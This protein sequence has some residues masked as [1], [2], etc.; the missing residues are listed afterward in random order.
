M[1]GSGTTGEMEQAHADLDLLAVPRRD[2]QLVLTLSARIGWLVAHR[3]AT[4]D[5]GKPVTRR[6][7]GGNG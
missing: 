3:S 7:H 2:G 5:L 1:G 4:N 6:T